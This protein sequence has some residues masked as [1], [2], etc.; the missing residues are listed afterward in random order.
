MH[1]AAQAY[2]KSDAVVVATQVNAPVQQL[3]QAQ[4]ALQTALSAERVAQT[5]VNHDDDQVHSWQ[6]KA[7]LLWHEAQNEAALAPR[8]LAPLEV[9][10]P[11]LAGAD[12]SGRGRPRSPHRSRRARPSRVRA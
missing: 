11:P 9:P 5:A 4:T 6:A 7:R 2:A 1:G 12:R 10:P 8:S 3:S